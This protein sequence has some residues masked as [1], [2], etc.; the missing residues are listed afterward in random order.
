MGSKV[1]SR[2]IQAGIPG[3]QDPTTLPLCNFSSSSIPN[4]T[5][6]PEIP[7]S[8]IPI[9]RSRSPAG[10]S[11]EI[12]GPTFPAIPGLSRIQGIPESRDLGPA[13]ILG[14]DPWIG[15]GSSFG[16]ILGFPG[17]Q[18]APDFLFLPIV[19]RQIPDFWPWK[20]IGIGNPED[21]E[22][23]GIAGFSRLEIRDL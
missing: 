10:P 3:F 22:N 23:L 9:Q 18:E 2:P 20:C 6:I 21:C 13:K 15:A 16:W 12:S 7:E 4:P 19:L 5:G 8:S 11:R 17:I 14:W 1:P